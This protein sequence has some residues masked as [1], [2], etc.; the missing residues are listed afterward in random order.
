M[1]VRDTQTDRQGQ[2]SK[3]ISSVSFVRIK[4]VFLQYTGDVDA[5]NDGPEFWNSN[6]VILR[7]FLTF[8][9]RRRVVPLRPIWTIM[10]A[11]KLDQNWVLVTNFRR[12]WLTLKGRSA[13]QR[14][15]DRQTNSAENKGPSV[16]QIMTI[17]HDFAG[18]GV[19]NDLNGVLPK[20]CLPF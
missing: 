12:N 7:I 20:W 13:G 18:K 17:K 4:S 15:T 16:P 8:S 10:A 3:C 2:S 19:L 5:K 11:A 14:Q 6:S 1:P 9:K